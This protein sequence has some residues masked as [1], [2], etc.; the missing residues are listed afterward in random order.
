[1]ASSSSSS[2]NSNSSKGCRGPLPVREPLESCAPLGS[3]SSSKC[4]SSSSSS[5]T[6][7]SPLASP[8]AAVRGGLFRYPPE[9]F[10]AQQL[11]CC[12]LLEALCAL[13]SRGAPPQGPGGPPLY[14]YHQGMILGAQGPQQLFIYSH[15]ILGKLLLHAVHAAPALLLAAAAEGAL[16]LPEERPLALLKGAPQQAIEDA[17]AALQLLY[18]AANPK[19]V[20]PR[21][22]AFAAAAADSVCQTRVECTYTPGNVEAME[23]MPMSIL[24]SFF[25]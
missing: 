2:S 15:V 7:G 24:C 5:S 9:G 13:S 25:I 4:S 1:E 20:L 19:E 3:S 18:E 12:R 21:K 22:S 6:C 14:T 23:R 11:I 8:E 17:V 16:L 10:A